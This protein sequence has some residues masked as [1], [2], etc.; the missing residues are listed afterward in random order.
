MDVLARD[1][2]TKACLNADGRIQE[3]EIEEGTK[4]ANGTGDPFVLWTGGK[5]ESICL[6]QTVRASMMASASLR[7]SG[8]KSSAEREREV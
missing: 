7:M 8:T 3:R 6:F 2:D 5:E 1:E 4:T